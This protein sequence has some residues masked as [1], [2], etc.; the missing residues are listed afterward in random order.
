MTETP[1]VQGRTLYADIHAVLHGDA[2]F[3]GDVI[4]HLDQQGIIGLMHIRETRTCG[5]VLTTKRM[6]WEEVDMV[7][8]HHQVADIEFRVH[9]TCGIRYEEGLDAQFVHH[10]YGEGDLLHRVALIE[11][12]ASL[13]GKD[14]HTAQLA[15]DQFAAMSFNS[16]D[17]EVGDVS[18]RDLA[19]VSNF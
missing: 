17:G 10:T 19:L 8:D 13:H 14:V 1:K 6:L 12:E 5:E 7:G 11:V 16:R 3:T 15:E 18:I 2:F 4:G 9:T